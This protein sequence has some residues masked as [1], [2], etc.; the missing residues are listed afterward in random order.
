MILWKQEIYKK[1]KGFKNLVIM[2]IGNPD[3]SDDGV[4]SMIGD[5]LSKILASYNNILVVNCYNRP[6]NFTSLVRKAMPDHIIILDSCISEKKPGTISIFSPDA[7]E[8]TDI[9]SHRVPAK[10]LSEYLE[11]ETGA[12]IVIVGIQPDTILKGQFISEPVRKAAEE[13]IE[14]LTRIVKNNNCG[15]MN[16]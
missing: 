5:K 2:C 1:I 4:G 8:E 14:F 15:D 9:L 16:A 11:K 6:E 12:S 3:S 7:L 10:L 13:I